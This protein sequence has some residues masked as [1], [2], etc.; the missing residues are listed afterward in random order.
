[1]AWTTPTAVLFACIGVLLVCMT[2][3]ELRW[4]TRLEQGFLPMATTRGDRVFISLLSAAF[5]HLAWLGLIGT[6][7][8]WA[9][10]IAIVWAAV[11][12]RWG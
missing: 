8:V 2:L 4:P 5:I 3:L 6:G 12:L 9:G 1:M 11:V 10:A 7:L